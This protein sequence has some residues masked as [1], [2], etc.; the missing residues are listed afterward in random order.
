MLRDPWI[1][2]CLPLL[3]CGALAAPAN[4][5]RTYDIGLQGGL[6]F[7]DEKLTGYGPEV[8]DWNPEFGLRGLYFL[9]DHWAVMADGLYAPVESN[10]PEGDVPALKLRTGL[11]FL[12]PSHLTGHQLFLNYG[13]GIARLSPKDG[14]SIGRYFGGAGLGQR[15]R[16]KDDLL[17][18]WEFRH[19][20]TTECHD[21]RFHDYVSTVMTDVHFLFGVSMG[22]G[23]GAKETTTEVDSD[24]DGVPDSRDRCAGTPRGT[25]VDARGCPLDTDGDGIS[26]GDDKCP[27]TPRGA[28]VDP[29]GCPLDTDGDGVYD[30]LDKCPDT[31]AGVAVDAGGCALADVN[32]DDDGDGVPNR[33]DKCPGTPKGTKVKADGCPEAAKLFQ[34][35]S[36]SLTL[37]GVNFETSSTTLTADSR[38]TLD[39]VAESLKA[40]PKVRVEIGGHTDSRGAAQ[41]NLDLSA[42][43]AASVRDYLV[44]KGVNAGQLEVKGYGE[45]QPIADN[46]TAAGRVKN[47]RVELKRI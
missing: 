26:D 42:G 37:E 43:R 16:L 15:I 10:L 45:T 30:G 7:A 34:E 28:R 27:D 17:F 25:I 2:W 29:L 12:Y 21:S 46:E 41:G 11:Q 38:K 4:A 3:L 44:G 22:F 9:G 31:K 23:G 18:H 1:R 39:R 36:A 14:D 24:R 8:R 40:W 47:R 32:A 5:E 13:M 19:D 20:R 6:L 35:G 33:L